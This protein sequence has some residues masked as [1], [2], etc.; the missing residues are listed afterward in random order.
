MVRSGLL[1]ARLRRRTATAEV[2]RSDVSTRHIGTSLRACRIAVAPGAA[3]AA[4]HGGTG[5]AFPVGSTDMLRA[6]ACL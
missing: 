6:V 5:A 4:P 3:R 2:L 1:R